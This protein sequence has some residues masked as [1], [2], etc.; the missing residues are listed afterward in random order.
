MMERL[1][2]KIVLV[3]GGGEGIGGAIVVRFACEGA[4]VVIVEYNFDVGCAKVVVIEVV[5]GF[6]L[7]V[8][9]DVTK[10]D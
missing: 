8:L 5:G 10:K 9:I 1:V 6:V 4:H 2:G 7:F 3:M